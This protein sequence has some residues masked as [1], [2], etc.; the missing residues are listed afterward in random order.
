MYTAAYSPDGRHLA[1]GDRDGIVRVRANAGL[2]LTAAIDL[3]CRNLDREL[4]AGERG[5]HLQSA[6]SDGRPCRQPSI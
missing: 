5:T 1:G 2:T 3:I 6:G 4:T